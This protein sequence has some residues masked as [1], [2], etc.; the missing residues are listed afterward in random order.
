MYLMCI[1]TSYTATT[2]N[3]I[4]IELCYV[5]PPFTNQT[6]VQ[7]F[8]HDNELLPGLQLA[9]DVTEQFSAKNN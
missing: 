3:T 5:G 7:G 8:I 1:T 6:I 2:L 9:V 4:L